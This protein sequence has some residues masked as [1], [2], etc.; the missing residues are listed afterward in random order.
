MIDFCPDGYLPMQEAIVRAAPYWVPDKVA[1][2]ESPAARESQTE[3]KN[4]SEAALRASQS[5]I[6]DE[7]RHLKEIWMLTINRMRGFLHQGVLK[8]YYFS[9]DGLHLVPRQFWATTHA[10]GVIESG[11]YWPFGA[12]TRWHER[13]PNYPLFIKNSELDALLS[14]RPAGKRELPRAKIPE[15]VVALRGLD[16]LPTRDKQ[17]AA[18]RKLP[19]FEQ[20]HLTDDAL[21]E[22]EKQVPRKPGRKRTSPEG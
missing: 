11:T 5:L 20:Y 13:R 6:P 2:L 21:R 19:E 7:P 4:D 14:E 8:A 22:A 18:L 12:P 16:H 15:L 9:H 3:P 10:D 17:R 1:A